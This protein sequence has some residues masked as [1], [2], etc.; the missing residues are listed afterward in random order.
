[1]TDL[2]YI[3]TAQKRAVKRPHRRTEAWEPDEEGFAKRWQNGRRPD[4]GTRRSTDYA[5]LSAEANR[6][7]AAQLDANYLD[8]LFVVDVDAPIHKCSPQQNAA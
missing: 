3:L 1:M 2:L 6:L 7:N 4:I 5:Q 8:W